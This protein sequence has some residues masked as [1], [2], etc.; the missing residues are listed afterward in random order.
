MSHIILYA[1][2]SLNM[3]IISFVKCL[4]FHEQCPHTLKQCPECTNKKT[5]FKKELLFF[6]SSFS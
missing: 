3:I 2:K 4:K 1:T 5:K 6:M